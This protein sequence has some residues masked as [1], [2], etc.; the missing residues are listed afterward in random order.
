[1][2]P[3]ARRHHPLTQ[4]PEGLCGRVVVVSVGTRLLRPC[5]DRPLTGFRKSPFGPCGPEPFR[6]LGLPVSR[7]AR[8][9][10]PLD[11]L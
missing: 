2:H 9:A 7:L 11:G 3:V 4:I 8:A 5:S 10:V 1:M 6:S